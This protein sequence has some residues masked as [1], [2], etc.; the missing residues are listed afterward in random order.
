M[1]FYPTLALSIK[2]KSHT[3]HPLARVLKS[4]MCLCPRQ[5]YWES[6]SWSKGFV[7][8][9]DILECRGLG[10]VTASV[11]SLLVV[12]NILDGDVMGAVLLT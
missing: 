5:V 4:W 11:Q 1:L 8:F 12:L 10:F 9:H 3:L 6:G 7:W 2:N